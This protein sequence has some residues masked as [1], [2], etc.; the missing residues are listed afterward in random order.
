MPLAVPASF[1]PDPDSGAL[2]CGLVDSADPCCDD[3]PAEPEEEL[4]DELRLCAWPFPL[5]DDEPER[6]ADSALVLD[7]CDALAS[8]VEEDVFS[9]SVSVSS[10]RAIASDADPPT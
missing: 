2:D 10:I 5:R 8:S 6:A 4:P 3:E 1:D 9:G 7:D